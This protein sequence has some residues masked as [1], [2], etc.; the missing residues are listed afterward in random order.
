MCTHAI[1]IGQYFLNAIILLFSL[2][3]SFSP[4]LW[5][6]SEHAYI[7]RVRCSRHEH[8]FCDFF[9]SSILLLLEKKKM[10]IITL[11]RVKEE[12]K[13]WINSVLSSLSVFFVV[14]AYMCVYFHAL[15]QRN[16]YTYTLIYI[17]IWRERER[18]ERQKNKMKKS[19]THSWWMDLDNET[20]Q[21]T[22]VDTDRL[23]YAQPYLIKK[24]NE[25]WELWN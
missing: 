5:D 17:Y 6:A 2:C 11:T 20:S 9:S 1:K 25:E 15:L 4:V 13:H 18:T 8:F 24:K 16:P 7:H 22:D 10:T 23:K 21:T 19:S 12:N 3:H 14:S